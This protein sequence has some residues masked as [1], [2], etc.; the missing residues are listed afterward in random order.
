MPANAAES[1]GIAGQA[2]GWWRKAKRQAVAAGPVGHDD[3]HLFWAGSA[4]EDLYARS[5]SGVTALLGEP[6]S[7]G[8]P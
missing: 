7:N 5:D 1:A 2:A 4:G 8:R 6:F 3:C